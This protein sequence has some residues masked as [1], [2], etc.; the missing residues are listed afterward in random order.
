MGYHRSFRHI[1]TH[2]LCEQPDREQVY[3]ALREGHCYIAVD[4]VAPAKGFRF[5]ADDL[6]MGAEAPAAPRTLRAQTPADARLRLLRDGEEIATADGRDLEQRVD[7]PGVYRVE[8]LRRSKGRERTWILSN[9]I[10]LRS[11]SE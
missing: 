4:S 2:V 1:R 6:P 8:A 11:G 5:E 9:P 10:Y 7:A 3:A